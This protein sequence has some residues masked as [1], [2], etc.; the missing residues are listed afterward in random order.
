MED[1]MTEATSTTTTEAP[2]AQTGLTVQDLTLVLQVIQ[3][4]SSRGAFKADELT[5]VGGL[6]D[7][8]FKFLESSGAITTK[9]VDA[10]PSDAEPTATVTETVAA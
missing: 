10:T 6:Y 5:A 2:A 4:A 3:V 9:P 1:N 7:R 8:I